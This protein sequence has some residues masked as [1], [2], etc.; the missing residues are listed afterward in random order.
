ME[1]M[2]QARLSAKQRK[3]LR[4]MQRKLKAREERRD[5]RTKGSLATALNKAVEEKL[6]EENP[7]D[8]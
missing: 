5:P 6:K 1:R 3:A 7:H 2:E 4:S 8:T